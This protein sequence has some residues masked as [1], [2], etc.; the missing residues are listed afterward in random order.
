M[1]QPRYEQNRLCLDS[2]CGGIAEPEEDEQVR[3][4]VCQTCETEFGYELV[5][6][7]TSDSSCQLGV[8]A[9]V[10][11][12]FSAPPPDGTGGP[13]GTVFLGGIGKRP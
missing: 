7:E 4:W 8:P 5:S 11:E 13:D 12:K 9:A 6:R 10:R 3:F 2:D 1:T